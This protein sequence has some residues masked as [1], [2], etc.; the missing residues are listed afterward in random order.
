MIKLINSDFYKLFRMKSLYVC[1]IVAVGLA[2][3]QSGIS[4]LT[5][6]M[7]EEDMGTS[8]VDMAGIGDIKDMLLNAMNG[9]QNWVIISII[10]VSLFVSI[11]YRA[12]TLKN[13][14]AKGFS[15]ESI[16]F[17][18]LIV[19]IVEAVIICYAY[20]IVYVSACFIF[21]DSSGLS[22]DF[23][24]EL[25]VNYAV[26]TLITIA[27]TSFIVMTAYLIRSTGGTIALSI[28]LYMIV[29]PMA[30][31]MMNLFSIL[32]SGDDSDSQILAA[33]TAMNENNGYGDAAYYWVGTL[34]ATLS[35]C[36][37]DKTIYI[38]VLIALAYLAL[39]VVI[40][41]LSFKKRDIK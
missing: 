4:R 33:T 15:R 12:G 17:S 19:S 2:L 39:S 5:V 34:S 22:A 10:A 3:L 24:S 27:S 14:V 35:K 1:L 18:K 30:L 40:G 9:D 32:N 7:L 28:C 13:I 31:Q 11:E 29:I 36:Y 37:A 21:F 20:I 16:F 8:L 38:P 6:N 26:N 23:Y 25:A 41:L